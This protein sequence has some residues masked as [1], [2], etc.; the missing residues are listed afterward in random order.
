MNKSL[1]TNIVASSLIML[2]YFLTPTY[3]N[4]IMLI[5]VFS[6]SG[7][8]TNWLAVHMLFE[9][10]PLLYG[11][12]VIVDRFEHIK[13]AIKKLLITEFFNKQN[14][15]KFIDSNPK[16][17]IHDSIDFDNI[18]KQLVEAIMTSS[19]GS[20]L[21]MVGG[22]QALAPI[23]TPVIDKLQDISKDLLQLSGNGE[24]RVKIASEAEKI[25]DSRLAELQPNDI[26]I[27]MQNI[28]KNHLGWLVV[29][30]GI[31]G[32]LIGLLVSLLG[33]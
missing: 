29:W 15:Q 4:I 31:F 6:L 24:I 16:T 11:S 30:G 7:S 9:K 17:N 32:G 10:V 33:M 21:S 3:G 14:L 27:I 12:G 19:V 26:K 1:Y 13:L 22:E 2:G 20:M 8:M 28:I 18:F 5:G 23:K 25:I